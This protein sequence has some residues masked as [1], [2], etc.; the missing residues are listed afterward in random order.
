MNMQIIKSNKLSIRWAVSTGNTGFWI[1]FILA[2]AF[3]T[4]DLHDWMQYANITVQLSILLL[5]VVS[6]ILKK[7]RSYVMHGNIM[8]LAVIMNAVALFAHMGPS[9]IWLP[10]EPSFVTV[11]G[12]IHAIIGT[13]AEVLGIWITIPWGFGNSEPMSCA[14]KRKHMRKTM[15]IW[16]VALGI[17]MI[18]YV[19]HTFFE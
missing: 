8:L 14:T 7:R 18:F 1:D 15:I 19:F 16:L 17:G 5:L 12:I 4:S 13:T 6:L 11:L 3:T 10:D 9:L 2:A